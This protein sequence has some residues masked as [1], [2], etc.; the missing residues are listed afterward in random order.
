MYVVVSKWEF[1]PADEATTMAAG[2]KMMEGIANWDGVGEAFNIRTGPGSVL[3]VIKYRDEETYNALVHAAD[4]P[5]DK[6]AAEHGI[7][8]AAT[9]LWS[10]RGHVV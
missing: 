5:F 9:W 7:D 6:L 3:A 8:Q 10:E 4:N 2:N 1:N